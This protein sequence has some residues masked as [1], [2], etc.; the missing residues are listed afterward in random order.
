MPFTHSSNYF[1]MTVFYHYKTHI[2]FQNFKRQVLK[3]AYNRT[4]SFAAWQPEKY[5]P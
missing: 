2:L 3:E 5:I 4:Y 1:A